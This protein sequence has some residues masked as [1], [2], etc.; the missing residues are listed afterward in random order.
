MQR[1]LI[2]DKM[3]DF[4][5]YFKDNWNR[6]AELFAEKEEEKFEE[7]CFSLYTTGKHNGDFDDD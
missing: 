2:G 5:Y 4:N 7:F 1:L 3:K 6:N